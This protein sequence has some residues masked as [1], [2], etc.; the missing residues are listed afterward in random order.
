MI[1]IVNCGIN[2]L[3]SVEKAFEHLGHE[4]QITRDP[5][6]V[7]R[8]E[9]LVL[10]GVGAFGAAMQ[11]LQDADLVDPLL[12]RISDGVPFLGVCLAL[13]LLF[14]W[15]EELG[16][17]AGL[18]RRVGQAVKFDEAPELKIPHMG[19]TRF[20]FLVPRSFSP[21]LE[22]GAMVYFVHS[23][24]C[25][26]RRPDVIAARVLTARVRGRNRARQPDGGAV[27]PGKEQ[28]CRHEDFGQ[29]RATLIFKGCACSSFNSS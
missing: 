14:D 21:G 22:H 18:G 17:H 7:M 8:A 10:P 27:S 12:D 15:S 2:N 4:V 3:R 6:V 9:R 23:Y 1:T 13:Q 28:R 26:A 5:Q 29:L 19:W 20:R 25:A 24:P 16:L 11:S